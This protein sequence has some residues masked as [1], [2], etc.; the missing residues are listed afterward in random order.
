MDGAEVIHVVLVVILLLLALAFGVLGLLV[1]GLLWLLAI[2]AV[3]ILIGAVMGY[4]A[5]SSP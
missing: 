4:R 1:K 5:R 2:A 3:L